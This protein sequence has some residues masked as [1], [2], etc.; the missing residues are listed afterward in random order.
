MRSPAGGAPRRSPHLCIS[1]KLD[2]VTD[3]LAIQQHLVTVCCRVEVPLRAWTSPATGYGR[4]CRRNL[5]SV[6]RGRALSGVG[7]KTRRGKWPAAGGTFLPLTVKDEWSSLMILCFLSSVGTPLDGCNVTKKFQ[8]IVAGGPRCPPEGHS[9]SP[10]VGT[11]EHDR[12]LC[13]FRG[14]DAESSRR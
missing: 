11:V 10:R 8:R 6:T 12:L 14:S 2:A 13:A 5:C 9:G 4:R 3:G 1:I 7:A